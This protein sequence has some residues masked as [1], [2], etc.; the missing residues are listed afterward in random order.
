MT[1]H[2][3]SDWVDPAYPVTGPAADWS[4]ID[5]VVIHYTA[6]ADC[7]DGDWP[8]V[9]AAYLRAIQRDYVTNRG[10]SIG[11]MFAVDQHGGQW[12]LRGWEFRSA[13]NK[14]HNEHTMPILCLVDGDRAATAVAV[15]AVRQLVAEGARRAGRELAIVGHGDIGATA[16]P[17]VG[18][19]AQVRAGVFT[20]VVEPEPEPTPPTEDD[21]MIAIF[22]PAWYVTEPNAAWLCASGGAV[23]PA[24]TFDTQWAAQHGVPVID[25]TDRLQ[26]ANLVKAAGL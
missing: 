5:T 20:P 10:Y 15:E 26:Y 8:D 12:Q 24:T 1:Y 17:G 22:R 2:P 3:R 25:V 14:G 7:P 19:A 21:P 13:A 11:Y 4:A 9:V 18:L 6:A 16:C 23:R